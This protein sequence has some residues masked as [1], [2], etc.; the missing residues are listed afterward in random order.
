MVSDDAHNIEQIEQDRD[1]D[2]EKPFNEMAEIL[3]EYTLSEWNLLTLALTRF[4]VALTVNQYI[5]ELHS[6]N[7]S[8]EEITART[9]NDESGRDE[10]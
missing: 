1:L 4:G 10:C 5:P 2:F 9:V 3:A 7:S 8:T 6:E